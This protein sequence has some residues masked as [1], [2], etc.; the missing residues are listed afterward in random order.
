MQLQDIR[1]LQ[2]SGTLKDYG[3]KLWLQNWHVAKQKVNFY[4]GGGGIKSLGRVQLL[5][6]CR[7][8]AWVTLPVAKVMREE[9][10]HNAKAESSLRRPPVPEHLPPKPECLLYC[11]MLSPIPLT[12]WGAVSPPP[13]LEKEL[14]Y[15]SKLIKIPGCDKSVSTYK[16][17]WRFS[18]LPEQVHPVTCDCLQPP[19]CERHEML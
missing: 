19:N 18:S 7:E 15:S 12:L 17:L 5:E 8:P 6:P 16:L 2:Q 14:T 13:L 3:T 4:V 11:F 10:R 9:A 1:C